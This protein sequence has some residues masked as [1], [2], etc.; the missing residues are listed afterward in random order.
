MTIW[1]KAVEALRMSRNGLITVINCDDQ[2]Q[3]RLRRMR[4]SGSTG[5]MI[6]FGYHFP[7]L[8]SVQG[9]L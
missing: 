6:N 1:L 8:L 4:Y 5:N 7:F 9:T 3:R 2:G